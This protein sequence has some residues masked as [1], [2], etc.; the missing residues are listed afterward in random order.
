M[1]STQQLHMNMVSDRL[2]MYFIWMSLQVHRTGG[3]LPLAPW[4]QTITRGLLGR[5]NLVKT[6]ICS[7]CSDR[8]VSS[9]RALMAR[10]RNLYGMRAGQTTINIRL[11][12]RSYCSYRPTRKP[13]LSAKHHRLRLEWVQRWQN[14][15]MA[16]WQYVIFSDESRFQLYPIDGRLEV[17]RLPGERFQQRCKVNKVQAWGGSVHVWGAFHHGAKS[18]L[19]LPNR[20][21]TGELYGGTSQNALVPFA[22]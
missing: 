15:T 8:I 1:T 16:H 11:L 2:A 10:I 4:C 7:W 19:V 18:P 3:M 12:C 20:Y 17:R 5:G 14:L 9:A 22:R 21:L 13:L 6:P